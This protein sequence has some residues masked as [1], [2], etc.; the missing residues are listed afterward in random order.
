[1]IAGYCI[2]GGLDLA[3]RCDFRIASAESTFGV[4][5]ARLGL[6]YGF[7]DIKRL[8]D[9]VGPAYAREILYTGRRFT[10]A[11]ALQMGLLHRVVA[12]EDLPGAVNTLGRELSPPT[13]RSP[14]AP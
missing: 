6:G 11:E 3:L 14:S 4:P 8:V 2:G 5:A 7:V 10:A 13:P 12:A 9:I 1:M